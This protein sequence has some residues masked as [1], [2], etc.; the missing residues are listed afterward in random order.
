MRV[1]EIFYS[2]QG[3]GAHAGMAAIFVRFSG[4]NLNCDFC[5][6][7]HQLYK[8]MTDDEIIAEIKKY[9]SNMVII[10][11]GEPALQLTSFLV[12]KIHEIGK[13]V[14]IETNGTRPIPPNVDWVTVSPKIPYIG[15][16]ARLAINKAQEVKIVMDDKQSYDDP[17]FGITAAHYFIQPCDTGDEIR[18]K[19][20]MNRCVNFIKDNPSWRLSLKIQ[21]ILNVR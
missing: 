9:P 1:N 21:K 14:A 2:L 6:T 13:T 18:N 7:T 16:A 11:G 10:T 3:E 15:N 4:C 17:T 5:D 12:A 8:D 20:I 19:E